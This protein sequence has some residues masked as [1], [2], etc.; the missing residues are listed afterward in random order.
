MLMLVSACLA[1][2]PC[3]YDGTACPD[4]T[5]MA[6]VREGKAFPVCPECLG[7][8]PVP[9]VPCELTGAGE[10]VLD[11]RARVLDRNGADRTAAF[12][13]GAQ[14]TLEIAHAR[15]ASAAILKARSPSCGCGMIY[16]GSFSGALAPGDGVTA[17]LLKRHGLRI[18]QC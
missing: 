15:G 18:E 10:D 16:D 1:G 11:G 13:A 9:R 7:G 12:L 8:L 4:E 6:L 14:R 3:R 2:E 17:A 5:I